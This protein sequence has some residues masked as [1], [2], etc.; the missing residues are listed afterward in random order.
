MSADNTTGMGM[1]SIAECVNLQHMFAGLISSIAILALGT[2]GKFVNDRLKL[3]TE[4]D[5]AIKMLQVQQQK[6][7]VARK[8]INPMLASQVFMGSNSGSGTS[9]DDGT[10]PPSASA[11]NADDDGSKKKKVK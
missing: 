10:V 7:E 5:S 3:Q 4:N 6:L 9:A 11:V 8:S 1:I 2:A